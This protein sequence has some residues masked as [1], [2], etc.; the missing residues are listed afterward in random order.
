[1]NG[2]I[3]LGRRVDTSE[4][5][6]FPVSALGNMECRGMTGSGKTSLGCLPAVIQLMR[7]RPRSLFVWIDLAGD[8][9]SYHNLKREASAEGRRF[10]H[11]HLDHEV[12]TDYFPPFQAIPAGSP[13]TIAAAELLVKSFHMDY[14]LVYGGQYFAQ[15]GASCVLDVSRHVHVRSF[16]RLAEYLTAPLNRRR[17]RDADQVRLIVDF[18]CE[19]PQL[20]NAPHPEDEIDINRAI[21]EAWAIYVS[22]PTLT[23][24]MSARYV[25]GIILET[26][27]SI[28]V[29]RSR[30]GKHHE[31]IY[32]TIDEVQELAGN[33]L[34][35]LLAQGR[36]HG[37]R[38]LI[39]YQSTS[40]L[41]TR[42]LDLADIVFENCHVHQYFS[43]VGDAE[44]KKLQSLSKDKTITL[45]SSTVSSPLRS[46]TSTREVI[47]PS[48]ER[49][50]IL[51][52]TATFGESFLV[53][54]D[55]GGYRE[56]PLRIVATHDYP[57]LSHVALPLRETPLVGHTG[58]PPAVPLRTAPVRHPPAHGLPPHLP[59][60]RSRQSAPPA[61]TD[62]EALRQR[63]LLVELL[64]EKHRAEDWQ[65]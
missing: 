25:A 4:P 18:L 36:K 60:A 58:A 39:A 15:Q 14:G 45:G 13:N 52:V 34:A 17:F 19:Y 33:S 16:R 53:V 56:G 47:M 22:T 6:G 55:G 50:E 65:T 23:H 57:N 37:L 59:A 8:L 28:A 31:L 40:Q 24:Q 12:H 26:L 7:L 32:V 54:N 41:E 42:D 2:Y 49:N 46:S 9:N 3:T 62:A 64:A 1:V 44:S 48:L 20:G 63:G 35:A 27:A 61:P 43:C 11:F 38:F 10:A 29:Q 21:T 5:A 30:A 51:D